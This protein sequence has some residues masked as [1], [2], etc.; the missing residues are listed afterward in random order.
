MMDRYKPTVNLPHN[1]YYAVKC[2]TFMPNFVNIHQLIQGW[3]GVMFGAWSSHK[4]NL[5]FTGGK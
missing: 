5:F 4:H 1:I 3:Q 2:V